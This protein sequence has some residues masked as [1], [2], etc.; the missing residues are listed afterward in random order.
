MHDKAR[1]LEVLRRNEAIRAKFFEVESEILTILRF[2]DLFAR[3]VCLIR[4]K[5]DIPHVWI[6]LFADGELARLLDG[7]DAAPECCPMVLAERGAVLPLLPPRGLPVLDN[8]DL[9]RFA[10]L[11]PRPAPA[12]LRSLAV[13]PLTLDGRLVGTLN[14][15]DTSPA[16]FR[17]DMDATLL[18]QLAVKVSLCLSNVTAHEKLARLAL[19]DPLTGL[20]NRRAMEERLHAEFLR[21]QRYGAVL[22]VAFI[23]M[24][25]FKGV[26]DTLGHDAGDAMLAFFATRLQKLARKVDS[27]A[28]YAGDEF[29]V[30]LPSTEAGQARAF[31]DRVEQ[32]FR[33][34]PVPGIDRLVRFSAGVASSADSRATSPALLLKC[35]DEDLFARKAARPERT[36]RAANQGGA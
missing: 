16:R 33:Y 18:A 32:F 22:S 2:E 27:C 19:C 5:F 26:N 13:A 9:G 21:A 31:M 1:I 17:P 3:L 8:R 14:Q 7:M 36:R 15:A 4:D 30:I 35:A 20:L 23:D 10:S 6:T 29:V 25:D 24:D 28:R 11:L 34:S 12:G